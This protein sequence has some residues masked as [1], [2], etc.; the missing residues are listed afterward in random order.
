MLCSPKI[1]AVVQSCDGIKIRLFIGSQACGPM[2]QYDYPDPAW[3]DNDDSG[4]YV[5]ESINPNAQDMVVDHHKYYNGYEHV[6]FPSGSW[7]NCYSRGNYGKR[8]ADGGKWS[9]HNKNLHPR[10]MMSPI[11]NVK[12]ELLALD[13]VEI[14]PLPDGIRGNITATEMDCSGSWSIWYHSAEEALDSRLTRAEIRTS[15]FPK[16]TKEHLLRHQ[17][18]AILAALRN[19]VKE[20]EP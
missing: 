12:T 10:L 20:I 19:Y 5:I 15:S 1:S 6:Y 11:N 14:L 17:T 9:G 7:T 18:N 2:L 16:I 3:I 4:S 13:G 8:Y